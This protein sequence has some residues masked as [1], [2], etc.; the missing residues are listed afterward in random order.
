MDESGLC[1]LCT[2]RC[3]TYTHTDTETY[4]HKIENSCR[5]EW[6]VLLCA[7]L[8]T[9]SICPAKIYIWARLLGL[10]HIVQLSSS[11]TDCVCVVY[12]FYLCYMRFILNQISQLVAYI[13]QRT[14]CGANIE[15][16]YLCYVQPENQKTQ[17][18]SLCIKICIYREHMLFFLLFMLCKYYASETLMQTQMKNMNKQNFVLQISVRLVLF[19]L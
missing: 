16:M 3:T 15:Q 4:V 14:V 7:P 19:Y 17:S 18:F 11:S 8:F 10:F 9:M 13:H 12:S 5:Y 2:H 1:A 6:S